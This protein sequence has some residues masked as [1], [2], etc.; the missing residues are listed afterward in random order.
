MPIVVA[1]TALIIASCLYGYGPLACIALSAWRLRHRDYAST[2]D[3]DDTNLVPA[4]DVFYSLVLC[5][6]VLFVLWYLADGMG[7]MFVM[8]LRRECNLPKDWGTASIRKYLVD[9]EA[10][11]LRDPTSMER[12]RLVHYAVDLMDSDVWEDN[13]SGA[14]MLDV[15]IKQG[16]DVAVRA[17]LLPSRPKVQKL[18]DMLGWRR[19][20]PQTQG[21]NRDLRGAAARV[22][23]NLAADIHLAN[24]PGA[25]RCVSSLLSLSAGRPITHHGSQEKQRQTTTDGLM[26][27]AVGHLLRWSERTIRE[28][29][30]RFQHDGSGVDTSAGGHTELILQGLTILERLA[31][32]HHNCRDICATPGLLPKITAP[33]YS[34]TLLQDLSAATGGAWRHVVS[35]SFGVVHQLIQAPGWTGARSLRH[36]ISS[37]GHAVSNLQSI[38]RH[39]HQGQGQNN[40]DHELQVRATEILTQLALDLSLANPSAEAKRSLV[41][42]QLRIFLAREEAAGGQQQAANP[43]KAT[44]G[45]TLVW[46]SSDSRTHCD[47][48]VRARHEDDDDDGTTHPSLT[49]V[50]EAKKNTVDRLTELLQANN[51]ITYRTR[52][53]Q[54]LKN[55]CTR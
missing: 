16:A 13:L 8:F 18:I 21:G 52:A 3:G 9:A 14:R 34:D 20:P 40:G 42:K 48:I 46:L 12:R 55:L 25:I 6:G 31:S 45:R 44:A 23:A 5:Q 53:A 10:R 22:V 37:H 41:G 26:L 36:E 35:A 43:L 7:F 32:D 39:H 11:C 1:L 54:I 24:F 2:G 38:I 28:L 29:H 27:K 49:E 15:F 47:F 30:F 33:L 19:G 4:L 51:N 17:L 50:T